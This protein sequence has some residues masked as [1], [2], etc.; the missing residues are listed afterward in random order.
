MENSA[1]STETLIKI[2]DDEAKFNLRA[3]PNSI[4]P[5]WKDWIPAGVGNFCLNRRLKKEGSKPRSEFD[6][7]Y[8][9]GNLMY[10]LFTLAGALVGGAHLINKYF[11]Q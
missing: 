8:L 9:A 6:V 1:K 5:S 3:Y 11:L 7:R 10:N 2:L 4:S